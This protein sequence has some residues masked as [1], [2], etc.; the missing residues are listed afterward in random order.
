MLFCSS[1]SKEFLL[2]SHLLYICQFLFLSYSCNIVVVSLLIILFFSIC[3][4]HEFHF[5]LYGSCFL[6]IL[7]FC[8]LFF[9]QQS[10]EFTIFNNMREEMTIKMLM[11]SPMRFPL[12]YKQIFGG[13]AN[14]H[15]YAKIIFV[16]FFY[17]CFYLEI[18][19]SFR[20]YTIII[21]SYNI[22]SMR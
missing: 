16:F 5:L 22:K 8:I 17:F 12:Y 13:H 19:L 4:R 2:S 10:N 9:K 6:Y 3:Q 20:H 11:N 21:N 1:F 14:N 7:F 15:E 18:L